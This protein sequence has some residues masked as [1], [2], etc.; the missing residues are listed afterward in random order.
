MGA[1]AMRDVTVNVVLPQKSNHKLVDWGTR[2]N[3]GPLLGDGVRIW[4]SPP[5]FHHT[6]IMVVDQEWC[7]IGSCNWDIRSFRLNFELCMEVYDRN[8]ASVLT[9]IM[10]GCRASELTQADLDGRSLPIRLRDAGA[11]LMLP[12]L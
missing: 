6:K 3:I 11:R 8:L 2:A 9:S 12:Y 4:R 7:L 10:E 5:P 1:A